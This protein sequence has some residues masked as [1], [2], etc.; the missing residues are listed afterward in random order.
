MV[1]TNNKRRGEDNGKQ[2][3]LP[4]HTSHEY[5]TM[6][7]IFEHSHV[8]VCNMQ[9]C[10][11]CQQDLLQAYVGWLLSY[12]SSVDAPLAVLSLSLTRHVAVGTC[13]V[14]HCRKC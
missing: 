9:V 10:C 11:C 8:T 1:P 7:V 12:L 4:T 2:T 14:I 3:V 6:H 13:T 5:W